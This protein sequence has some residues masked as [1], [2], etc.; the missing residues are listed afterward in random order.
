MRACFGLA[1]VTITELLER[2]KGSLSRPLLLFC[3]REHCAALLEFSH[4]LLSEA[5]YLLA[6]ILFGARDGWLQLPR[7]LRDPVLSAFVAHRMALAEQRKLAPGFKLP[8]A[9]HPFPL[10]ERFAAPPGKWNSMQREA[11]LSLARANDWHDCVQTRITLAK[12]DH[13]ASFERDGLQLILP[14]VISKEEIVDEA[15]FLRR[16]GQWPPPSVESGMLN[17][18][19]DGQDIGAS[20]SGSSC[21]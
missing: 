16:L 18:L 15:G 3:L 21:G 20:E 1:G 4:P 17:K 13:P 2:H 10:R 19:A 8:E 9:P 14:G 6:G 12:G 7:E 11:A 5:E